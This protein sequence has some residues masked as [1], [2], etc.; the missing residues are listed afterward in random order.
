MSIYPDMGD[1]S[2]SEADLQFLCSLQAQ[3]S[4]V[5]NLGLPPLIC[6]LTIAREEGL[7][8]TEL[9]EKTASPQQSVSRYV[10]LLLGR[11][12]V[13]T[14]PSPPAALVEQRINPVDPRKRALFLT[15]DGREVI[16]G[17]VAIS[18]PASAEP[19]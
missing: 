4:A 15:D 5:E 12:Q 2:F 1:K 9:A 11:Y 8:V 7:S 13:E 19:A 6:L 14:M 3:L 10:S 16:S 17:L 18:H